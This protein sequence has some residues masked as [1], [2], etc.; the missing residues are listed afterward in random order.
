[1][2]YL[3]DTN[4]VWFLMK[5]DSSVLDHLERQLRTDVMLPQPVVAEI[6]YGLSRLPR[7][8]RQRK[9]RERFALLLAELVRAEWTD[10]V[11]EAFGKTK[12]RLE[13]LGLRLEDF[14]VAIAAHALVYPAILVTDN[15]S[16]MSR[17]QGLWVENWR[18][19]SGS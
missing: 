16:Q 12:A 6:E 5:G 19:S 13:S 2:K 17:I 15:V 4:T 18:D 1:L 14:D 11:S 8:R 7:S 10:A 9:L 3:L